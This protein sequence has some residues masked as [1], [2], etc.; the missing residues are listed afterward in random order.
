MFKKYMFLIPLTIAI[1]MLCLRFNIS[2]AQGG[3]SLPNPLGIT[4]IFQLLDK[5]M[6]FLFLFSIP[7]AIIMLMYAGFLYI[8]SA[9]NPKNIPNI[10]KIIQY[11][12]IGFIIVLL[13]KGIIYVVKD[14][15]T[16]GATVTPSI[17]NQGT[18]PTNNAALKW[19]CNYDG[20]C[21]Q[22]PDGIFNTEQEC[23]NYPCQPISSIDPGSNIALLYVCDRTLS[24]PQCKITSG[25][26]GLSLPDCQNSC[27]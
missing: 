17:S 16:N 25:F 7:V 18:S 1:L 10:S 5:I 24:I 14:V 9:G 27:H 23:R 21:T 4:D 26:A 20:S 11:T 6:G 19:A 2:L 8:T 12:L 13:A 15:L 3:V 22:S